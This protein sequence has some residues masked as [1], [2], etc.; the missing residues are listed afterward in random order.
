MQQEVGDQ[1]PLQRPSRSSSSSP[2]LAWTAPRSRKRSASPAT[3]PCW[4][5]I[6]SGLGATAVIICP[7]RQ[8]N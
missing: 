3:G 5:R 7:A 4:E 6:G 2:R 1:R 8:R